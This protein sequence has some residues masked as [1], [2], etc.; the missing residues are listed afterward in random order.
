MLELSKILGVSIVAL[1]GQE[2]GVQIIE[3]DEVAYRKKVRHIPFMG[4]S[5]RAGEPAIDLSQDDDRVELTIPNLPYDRVVA[6][7][8]DGDSMAPNLLNGDIIIC[9]QL[10][11]L[12]TLMP[13][14]IYVIENKDAE[15]LIKYV[16][17]HSKYLLCRSNDPVAY[18]DIKID[19]DNIVHIYQFRLRLTPD[20]GRPGSG[21]DKRMSRIEAWINKKFR[22]WE[23]DL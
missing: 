10:D 5:A 13:N 23:D 9:N 17:Q 15:R 8:V 16:Q 7:D 14:V 19:Y 3:E 20:I 18:P 1:L 21:L 22:G 11:R 6:F 4:T 12:A 2:G